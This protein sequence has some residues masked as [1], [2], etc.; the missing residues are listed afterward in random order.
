[1]LAARVGA[2]DADGTMAAEG[3]VEIV[4]GGGCPALQHAALLAGAGPVVHRGRWV[5]W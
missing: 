5:V 2:G 3:G 4:G 1:M